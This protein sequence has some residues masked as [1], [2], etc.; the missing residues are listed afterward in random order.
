MGFSH[1][2]IT[3]PQPQ[4]DELAALLAPLGIECVAQPAFEYRPV[5][6]SDGQPDACDALRSAGPGDLVIMIALERS[7]ELYDKLQRLS[8]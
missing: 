3:R 8:V 7:A 5:D 2:L 1:A 4:G 6:A